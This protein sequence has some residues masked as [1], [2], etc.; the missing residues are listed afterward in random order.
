MGQQLVLA[1][2]K[3][4]EIWAHQSCGPPPHHPV[5]NSGEDGVP[6]G[7][8]GDVR[9]VQ[10]PVGKLFQHH[11]LMRWRWVRV[12]IRQRQVTEH[13]GMSYHLPLML[14]QG[15]LV[16]SKGNGPTEDLGERTCSIWQFRAKRPSSSLWSVKM[17]KGQL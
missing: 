5:Q 7:A 4:L 6:H 14:L 17:V 1:R 10:R 11:D 9:H 15:V 8:A 13:I 12:N 16:A 2:S 3:S